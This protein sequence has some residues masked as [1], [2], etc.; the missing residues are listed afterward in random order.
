MLPR[1]RRAAAARRRGARLAQPRDAERDVRGA[2]AGE[3][4]RV[5]RHLRRRLA[6]R[7]RGEQPDRLAW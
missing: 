4:E 3:V 5:E 7:L 1:A 6:D 2:A